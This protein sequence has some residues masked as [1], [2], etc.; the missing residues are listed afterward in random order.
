MN[1]TRAALGAL[2]AAAV[3]AASCA[4]A[5]PSTQA[6]VVPASSDAASTAPAP[7]PADFSAFVGQWTGHGNDMTIESDG[8]FTMEERTYVDC[9]ESA[10]PCDTYGDEITD[11]AVAH[12]TLESVSG[13]S[14]TGSISSTTDSTLL[15]SGPVTFDLDASNDVISTLNLNW[16][17][18]DAPDGTCD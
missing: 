2:A 12:G 17:G 18:P 9:A 7:S 3:L 16:C 8:T 6:V 11:G 1:T 14:A 5:G 4:C 13:T 15:P 10:P